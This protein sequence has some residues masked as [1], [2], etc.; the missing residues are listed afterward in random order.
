MSSSVMPRIQFEPFA[1]HSFT[2]F[3]P[4][5]PFPKL[6]LSILSPNYSK[7]HF[8]RC[9]FFFFFWFGISQVIMHDDT[10]IE[11]HWEKH[12]I[13]LQSF[14]EEFFFFLPVRVK[15]SWIFI[16]VKL[17]AEDSLSLRLSHSLCLSSIFAFKNLLNLYNHIVFLFFFFGGLFFSF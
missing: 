17:S 4:P 1:F 14:W 6:F 10:S 11:S 8:W 3:R 16:I 2:P 13:H 9:F 12:L 15:K 7:I 5:P